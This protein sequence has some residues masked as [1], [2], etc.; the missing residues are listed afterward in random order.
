M[1]LHENMLCLIFVEM[2]LFSSTIMKQEEAFR[3]QEH[4]ALFEKF[5]FCVKVF[6]RRPKPG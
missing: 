4:Q 2:L 3:K 6:Q 1:R 5:V